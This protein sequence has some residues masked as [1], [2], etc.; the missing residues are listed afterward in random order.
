MNKIQIAFLLFLAHMALYSQSSNLGNRWVLSLDPI[1][2]VPIINNQSNFFGNK[3]PLGK[4]WVG[5]IGIELLK[6]FPNKKQFYSIS[7]RYI[8][9][10]A[11]I[12][13]ERVQFIKE[14]SAQINAIAN[15]S[16]SSVKPHY[17][18][19]TRYFIGL[20][21]SYTYVSN[22]KLN[23]YDGSY[24]QTNK[25]VFNSH[26]IEGLLNVGILE[27]VF[28]ISDRTSLSKFNISCRF[29]ILNTSNTFN[30]TFI[31]LDPEIYEFQKSNNRK[32]SVELQY[33]HMI[34]MKKNLKSNYVIKIDTFWNEVNDPL[35]T[36][37]PTLVNNSLPKKN[38]YGNFFFEILL[39][40]GQDSIYSQGYNANLTLNKRFN[41]FGIGYTFNFLGNYKK[42][43][44]TS[45]AGVGI[46]NQGKGWRRNM[47]ISAGFR[48]LTI[49]GNKNWNILNFYA[50]VGLLKAGLKLKNTRS[51]FELAL[52]AGYQKIVGPQTF[53]NHSRTETPEF[54]TSNVFIAVGLKNNFIKF[55][56]ETKDFKFSNQ[57]KS[58]NIVYSIGI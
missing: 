28:N 17:L 24:T 39:Y 14:N 2:Q 33:I 53:L 1:I 4:D 12:N 20:G 48:Q 3:M 25:N 44:S 55:E 36:F 54:P 9:R 18:D 27:D 32:L 58:F 10:D 40:R 7:P 21:L 46:Y 42:D 13:N 30:N 11:V 22:G 57:N 47:F 35:K 29:P 41:G 45:N 34:D 51:R 52:G 15:Y 26:R 31:D 38:F 5:G 56:Y 8:R 23:Y 49:E 43:Y 16:F 19:I 50:P 6:Y 37:V